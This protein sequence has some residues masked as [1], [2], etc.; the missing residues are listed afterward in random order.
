MWAA[1]QSRRLFVEALEAGLP[2]TVRVAIESDVM[3]RQD[4][5]V[6]VSPEM[7]GEAQSK[8]GGVR[9]GKTINDEFMF[10]LVASAKG[11]TVASSS[12]S[13]EQLAQLLWNF[14][15][16]SE[17]LVDLGLDLKG[18]EVEILDLET[19][20]ICEMRLQIHGIGTL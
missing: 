18:Y 15:K 19:G 5:H 4:W 7:S 8:L 1:I 12:E 10:T 16:S 11:R 2:G 9:P 13:A 14:M 3:K 6:Y 17:S 20:F